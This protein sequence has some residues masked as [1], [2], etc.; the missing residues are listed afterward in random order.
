M[1]TT[2]FRRTFR[3]VILFVLAGASVAAAED[4]FGC[5]RCAYPLL[6]PTSPYRF[7]K[8]VGDGESGATSCSSEDG[9]C[10]VG[11]QTCFNTVVEDGG[12]SGGGGGTGGGTAG[13]GC[14]IGPIGL[15]P[16]SCSY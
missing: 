12:G 6:N 10:G 3:L 4:F 8:H 7:C 9:L 15:C 1:S 13:G 14:I 16:L 2:R 5:Y 11:S